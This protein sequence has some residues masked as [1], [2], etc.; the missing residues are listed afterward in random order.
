MVVDTS[1]ISAIPFSEA[2]GSAFL[3]ALAGP[4]RKFMS[5]FNRLETAIVVEARKGDTG[6]Q[7]LAEFV[8]ASGIV[9]VPFDTGQTELALDAWRWYGKGRHPAG[10]NPGDCAA[11]A[12]ARFLAEPLLYKGSNFSKT[13]VAGFVCPE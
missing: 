7:A 5:A 2:E 11:Y 13:D 1:A 6:S 8:A 9:T 12:L 4:E 10:L 3:Q